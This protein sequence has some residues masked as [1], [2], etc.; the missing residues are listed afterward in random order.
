MHNKSVTDFLS[1]EWWMG[2]SYATPTDSA[3]M[4]AEFRARCDRTCTKQIRGRW[5]KTSR[6][7]FRKSV[8]RRIISRSLALTRLIND[9][10]KLGWLMAPFFVDVTATLQIWEHD[11][12]SIPRLD[13]AVVNIHL[14]CKAFFHFWF[15]LQFCRI[16]FCIDQTFYILYHIQILKFCWLIRLRWKP[17]SKI[18]KF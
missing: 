3:F 15:S 6:R 9:Q 10:I 7:S 18:I 14:C 2:I 11:Y 4:C 1:R 13:Y 16:T 12:L 17:L 5:K 8:F